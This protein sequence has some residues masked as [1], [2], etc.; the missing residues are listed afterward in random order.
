MQSWVNRIWYQ[1]HWLKW[2]L[3]PLSG[4]FWLIS[5]IRRGLFNFGVKQQTQ[6]PVPVIIVGNI[7]AGGSGKTPTVI[8]LIELLRA[9]GYQPGV[10]SRGYG[11]NINGT[12]VVHTSSLASE[13][14]DE[15]SLIVNRTQVPMVVG[16]K[17]VDAANR[18]LSEF[19]VNVI[20]SD[21]GLQHYALGR[22]IEIA[23]VDGERRYGNQCL[24]PAGP[25][26][27]SISRLQTID[28]V[29]N[30]GAKAQGDEVPMILEPCPPLPVSPSVSREDIPADFDNNQPLVAMAGIG[31]P[32]RF[33]D[34]LTSQG[35][36]L[37]STQAFE[38]H[39]AYSEASLIAVAGGHGLIMTEKDAVKCRGFA[40][41]N[42]WYLPV[43]AKLTQEF[44]QTL[45]RRLAQVAQFKKE[46]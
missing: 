4:L 13:V 32:Q 37:A 29:I 12:A 39:Q 26:R 42:W 1:G 21:D 28:F 5:T 3:L 9:H 6:L 34:S 8:Y 25:L 44:D 43:N 27:E 45:L 14:G 35:F 41:K 15:P 11:G 22:D 38:D 33:F 30:N 46:T 36:N 19:D 17:R 16:A 18:L 20:I 24:I 10:V 2:L 31:N 23:L 40:H 7:T